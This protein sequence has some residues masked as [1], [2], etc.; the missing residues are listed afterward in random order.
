MSCF[1]RIGGSASGNLC[2]STTGSTHAAAASVTCSR[3]MR[4]SGAPNF[5]DFSSDL[6]HRLVEESF[7]C[8]PCLREG[9]CLDV[10]TGPASWPTVV[11][12][13]PGP[14]RRTPDEA[15]WLCFLEVSSRHRFFA[16]RRISAEIL[17]G[18]QWAGSP[19]R[20]RCSAGSTL[21]PTDVL[22]LACCLFI[23]P[24]ELQERGY[25][26]SMRQAAV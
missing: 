17:A 14:W 18:S 7:C 22:V 10:C 12:Q 25:G 15:R 19:A 8:S 11:Q 13:P 2:F 26:S 6:S 9:R 24:A 16:R 20:G 1:T 5:P 3:R 23:A 21:L 4:W